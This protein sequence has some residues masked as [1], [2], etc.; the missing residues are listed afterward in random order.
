M[1]GPTDDLVRTSKFLSYVL[2]HHPEAVDL[3]LGDGG[4]VEID[5]LLA[6]LA[7]S[8]RPVSRATLDRVVAG[9]DKRRLEVD[10]DRIR[11]AQGHT[12]PVDLGLTPAVPPAVLYHGTVEPFLASIRVEGLTPRGRTHV[13]LSADR[14]T[15]TTVGA[16]RGRPVVLT[17]DAAAMHGAGHEFYRAANGVWLTRAVPPQWISSGLTERRV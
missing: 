16:R 11:A 8:G 14:Q 17:V 7:R 5:T 6:A 3:E 12:V 10:G 1:G 9:T 2:R 4:W 13:H 15:A